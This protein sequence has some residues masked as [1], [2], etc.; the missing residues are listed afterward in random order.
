MAPKCHGAGTRRTYINSD[1]GFDSSR[2]RLFAGRSGRSDRRPDRNDR[3][4]A[5][6]ARDPSRELHRE[7]HGAEGSE[8]H[9]DRVHLEDGPGRPANVFRSFL[10]LINRNDHFA[11]DTILGSRLHPSDVCFREVNSFDSLPVLVNRRHRGQVH[12]DTVSPVRE[13]DENGF[14]DYDPGKLLEHWAADVQNHPELIV[15]GSR[16]GLSIGFRF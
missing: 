7:D 3:E 4:P 16:A 10:N 12:I 8:A 11:A 2:L 6:S 15:P 5:Q 13:C 14:A 1:I 9:Q